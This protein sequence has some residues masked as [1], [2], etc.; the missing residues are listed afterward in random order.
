[1][2]RDWEADPERIEGWMKMGP[3]FKQTWRG[4]QVYPDPA[5]DRLPVTI[6]VPKGFLQP[7]EID[8]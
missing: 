8:G 5:H 7:K 2:K 3:D 4:W 6:L 1:M